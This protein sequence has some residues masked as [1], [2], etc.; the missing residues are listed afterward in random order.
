MD[1]MKAL[2]AKLHRLNKVTIPSMTAGFLLASS[3][4]YADM[5]WE[6]PL[7]TIRDSVTG[8]RKSVV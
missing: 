4:C 3:R 1:I 2:N 8:D 6:A 5:P 7:E